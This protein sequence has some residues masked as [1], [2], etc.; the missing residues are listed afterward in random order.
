VAELFQQKYNA[1]MTENSARAFTAVLALAQAINTAKST[2]PDAIRQGLTGLKVPAEQTIMP[3][4]GI[5]F[6]DKGQNTGARGVVQQLIGGT[7]KVVFPTDVAS[8]TAVWPMSR[9]RQ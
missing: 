3:W 4:T 5:A 6:D 8:A 1:P 9:A 7:Y 2:R